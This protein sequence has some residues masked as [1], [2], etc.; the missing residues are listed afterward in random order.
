M[1]DV[2]ITAPHSKTE[3]DAAVDIPSYAGREFE[4]IPG[5]DAMATF[6]TLTLDRA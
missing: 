4:G 2:R 6:M 5:L 1:S 3:L